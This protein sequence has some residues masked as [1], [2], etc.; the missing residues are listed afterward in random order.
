MFKSTLSGPDA[1]AIM[2][3]AQF[4][5][6][7]SRNGMLAG[8]NG[9]LIGEIP[10]EDFLALQALAEERGEY[11]TA[12]ELEEYLA[13]NPQFRTVNALDSGSR[14]QVRVRR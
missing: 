7:H 1:V 9:R 5:K 13:L 8:G 3:E 11:L 2:T 12:R 4:Q 6:N 10:L 14:G